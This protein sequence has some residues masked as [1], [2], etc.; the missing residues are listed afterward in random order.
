ML[1]D[2]ELKNLDESRAPLFHSLNL[3]D[4]FVE[5]LAT[6]GMGFWRQIQP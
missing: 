2:G 4:E 3:T 5:Y 1:A 6:I